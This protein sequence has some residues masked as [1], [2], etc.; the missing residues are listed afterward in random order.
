[1]EALHKLKVVASLF[2]TMQIYQDYEYYYYTG[3]NFKI[4]LSFETRTNH[5]M[6]PFDLKRL[7][8]D[9]GLLANSWVT[10]DN[11]LNF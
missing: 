1:M 3:T 4:V 11:F 8:F 7:P 2:D 10:L 5:K 6:L 9:L